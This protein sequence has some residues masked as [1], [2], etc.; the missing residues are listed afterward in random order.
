MEQTY[1]PTPKTRSYPW[2][3]FLQNPVTV[4]ELRSRMRG[5]RGF[6]VLTS[7]LL[8]MSGF[9]T[10]VY[11]IYS[12]AAN[13]PAGPNSRQ[14][15]KVVFSAVLAVETFLV[16]FIGPAFTMAAI[17]GEKERQTYD[18]LRT[19]LLSAR[20]FVAGKLLSA[21]SYVF[22]LIIV[23][24]PIQSIAFLLGGVSPVE[25]VLSQF[26]VVLSAV[27]FALIGLFFSSLMRT[28]LAAS[29]STFA[30]A[31]LLVA[32]A[33]IIAMVFLMFSGPFLFG[34]SSPSFTLQ[35]FLI[36]GGLLLASTNFPATLVL[37][38]VFLLEQNALFIFPETIDGHT[39]YIFS[40]WF[41]YT[42]IYGLL[43]LLLFW[44]TVRRVRRIADK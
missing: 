40:P 3:K 14:A 27:T 31:I 7:Y 10:L 9:I 19:T 43:S 15:G 6:A 32:G 38:D 36:Y 29:V 18:L 28:T 13:T 12:A 22:L 33:P 25:V 17:S 1:Q 35:V 41:I 4:K 21:L 5:R 23:A 34:V 24:I 11:L 8:F 42:A 16:V 39:L 2:D 30:I 20:S 44:A 37:S 26:L